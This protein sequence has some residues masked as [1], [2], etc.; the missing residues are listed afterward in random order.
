[1]FGEADG[2]SPDEDEDVPDQI[3]GG[4]GDDLIDVG[5]TNTYANPVHYETAAGHITMH[6]N[7]VTGHGNDRLRNV[8]YVIGTDGNDV[9]VDGPTAR[10]LVGGLCNDRIVGAGG[11]DQLGDGEGDDVLMGG[12]GNDDVYGGAGDDSFLPGVGREVVYGAMLRAGDTYSRDL[13]VVHGC[14]FDGAFWY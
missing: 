6:R 4:G 2:Y 5:S 8:T 13:D 11:G 12:D 10:T 14:E 1:M 3:W 7:R 9:M